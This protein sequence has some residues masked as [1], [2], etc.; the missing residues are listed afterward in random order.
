MGDL[1]ESNH[2]FVSGYEPNNFEP[3][4]PKR[5]M[6]WST[7]CLWKPYEKPVP[8]PDLLGFDRT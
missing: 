5:S 4:S 8:D 1:S 7:L 2:A 6:P 3:C